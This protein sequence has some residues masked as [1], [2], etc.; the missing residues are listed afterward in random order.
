MVARGIKNTWHAHA[1]HP[2]HIFKMYNLPTPQDGRQIRVKLKIIARHH[3][4]HSC[5]A[6]P[7]SQRPHS[8]PPTPPTSSPVP[9]NL[10]SPAG[11]RRRAEGPQ[12]GGPGGRTQGEFAS[13]LQDAA[14]V[15]VTRPDTNAASTQ[16]KGPRVLL[17]LQ[18]GG[19]ICIQ[20][21][22]G[23]ATGGVGSRLKRTK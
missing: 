16:S 4:L 23:F 1:I 22:R 7:P 2:H 18:A 15:H 13:V 9:P 11:L 21:R 5:A 20:Q 19:K 3:R 6:Q 8:D 14:R 12:G 10:P 17:R